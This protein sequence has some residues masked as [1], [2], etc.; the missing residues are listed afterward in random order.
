MPG[1]N[2]PSITLGWN[3]ESPDN[4]DTFIAGRSPDDC[5]FEFDILLSQDQNHVVSSG[6]YCSLTIILSVPLGPPS[7]FNVDFGVTKNS[8][9]LNKSLSWNL[10]TWDSPPLSP[11][12]VWF[13]GPLYHLQMD[14]IPEWGKNYYM[15]AFNIDL[16]E[17]YLNESSLSD[18]ELT[19]LKFHSPGADIPC[20]LIIHGIFGSKMCVVD[21]CGVCYGDGS[22]CEKKV[23]IYPIILPAILSVV[24]L[25][26]VILVSRLHKN[27]KCGWLFTEM[28]HKDEIKAELVN[29]EGEIDDQ[30]R[31]TAAKF[32]W[33]IKRKDII[34]GKEMGKG[35]SGTVYSGE[36]RGQKIAIKELSRD[37][38]HERT[39]T[40]GEVKL[41]MGLRPHKNVIQI[42]GV[43]LTKD[44][45]YIVMSKMHT[46][47][48]KIVY[49]PKKHAKLSL[50]DMYRFA[51]GICA[52]MIHLLYEGICHRDLAARNICLSKE[53]VPAI[54]DFGLSRKLLSTGSGVTESQ[55]GPVAWMAPE[56]FHQRYSSKSDVWSFGIVIYEIVAGKPPHDTYNDLFD[57]ALK[58]RDQNLRPTIPEDCDQGLADIMEMCWRPNPA[59]RP[60]F[61]E[62]SVILKNRM[63]SIEESEKI[64]K[65]VIT[66]SEENYVQGFPSEGGEVED[67]ELSASMSF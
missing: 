39:K 49:N 37:L 45:I 3:N 12:Y 9:T 43:C 23:N 32:D 61:Q 25:L 67:L 6:R 52:G 48:D 38:F 1:K 63:N 14:D 36:W 2:H 33:L 18:F 51:S 4:L 57:L 62:L 26:A 53:S 55:M 17:V 58:I 20:S 21:E 65:V 44:N 16:G 13:S 66:D 19:S 24:V 56:N 28:N 46:S 22:S 10:T 42:L 34:F 15:H 30:E 50:Y 60:T 27:N 11:F 59:D 7:S 47:L 41:A 29:I 40:L 64:E 54:T 35:S 31:T 8:R 5:S